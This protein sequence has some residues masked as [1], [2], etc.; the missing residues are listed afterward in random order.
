M[1][2]FVLWLLLSAAST[3]TAYGEVTGD[4]EAVID[5]TPEINATNAT[6][7]TMRIPLAPGAYVAANTTSAND[8]LASPSVTE[9]R[10]QDG[11]LATSSISRAARNNSASA[12][13]NVS[14]RAPTL[15]PSAN[16]TCSP[17]CK[18]AA[19]RRRRRLASSPLVRGLLAVD[20]TVRRGYAQ[21]KRSASA[22]RNV[23]K[24]SGSWCRTVKGLVVE[25]AAMGRDSGR[26]ALVVASVGWKRLMHRLRRLLGDERVRKRIE[27]VRNA[28]KVGIK[29]GHKSGRMAARW[30]GVN[31]RRTVAKVQEFAWEATRAEEEREALQRRRRRSSGTSSSGEGVNSA[32]AKR[33]AAEAEEMLVRQ[34]AEIR[35]IA[36]VI[37]GDHYKT[38]GV[39]VRA[40]PA[41]IKSAFRKLARLLHPDKCKV[42]EA[43]ATFL[44]LQAAQSVLSDAASR[45]A[46]DRQ[47][48]IY[49]GDIGNLHARGAGA[50]YY[51]GQ[52]TAAYYARRSGFRSSP[53]GYPTPRW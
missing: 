41:A 12:A 17:R 39:D 45:A 43:H 2:A 37:E 53:T 30:L 16:E 48:A 26:R 21:S 13:Y 46:Y 3:R 9:V 31:A 1:V 18:Q 33:A 23:V 19:V 44:R 50:G 22:V 15:Q 4:A 20:W 10:I 36:S 6:N 24:H 35:R 40:S 11:S 5:S 7:A 32:D 42:P 51:S 34:R 28:A 49:G 38:L 27:Q 47:R 8:M 29:F 14:A 52:S 25:G